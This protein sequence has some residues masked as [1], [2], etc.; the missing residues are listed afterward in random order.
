MQIHVLFG[1]ESNNCADLAE[2][3]AK[4]LNAAG[5]PA[6]AVDMADFSNAA[7]AQLHTVLI[8][9]STYGNGD[10]PG[11]AEVLHAFV[12]KKSPPLPATLR[13]AVC[14]LGDKTYDRFCQCGK[15][16]DKRLGELGATRLTDRQDCDVDFDVPWKAWL[17]RVIAALGAAAAGPSVT[18][19]PDPVE[20]PKPAARGTRRNPV[21][22][23]VTAVRTLSGAGSTKE[24]LHVE[25]SLAGTDLAYEAGDSL[26]VYP[27]NDPALVDAILA[28]A[29]CDGA[30]RVHVSGAAHAGG[31][32]VGAL[33][34]REA[35]LT[36]LDLAHVD[37][38]LADA[39]GVALPED[40]HVLDMLEDAQRPLTP[41]GLVDALRP[42]APRPY[43]LASS[44]RD[45][46]GHA[47]FT[48]D[49]VRWTARGRARA[50]VASAMFADRAPIGTKVPV[51]LHA[52][53]HFRL[54][55]AD[56]PVIM[57]G[58]GTGVAPFRAFLLERA[59]TGA[60]GKN[61]L[62]FGARNA[63]CDFY[64]GDEFGALRE[65]GVL[66]RLDCAFSR[67]TA[68]RVYVQQRMREQAT[69]LRRW[70]DEGAFVYLCGDAKRMAPDVQ[71]A[72]I[73]I[74]SRETLDRLS[75]TGRYCKDV[76]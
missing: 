26:G 43:S 19:A 18:A 56:V 11:N 74:L 44:P 7:L 51:Y 39:T 34:L 70:V 20:A 37:P 36:R 4:A 46:P 27:T 40:R 63:A 54:P 62:F 58:P 65:R 35:L 6:K 57:V 38:R 15:D 68:E 47:H 12:M 25:L 23:E 64:Y 22:A 67:D 75:E 71:A 8:V 52:S 72:L 53:P 55:A 28:A 5:H 76:Y 10:P 14:A 42:L 33:T 9:T 13:F 60:R 73:E 69:E 45:T 24:T 59:A 29:P 16:F 1:T 21:L 32:G 66:T 49:V 2:Q 17:D 30:A 48:I 50:G 3:T 41:Q 31:L 61:W